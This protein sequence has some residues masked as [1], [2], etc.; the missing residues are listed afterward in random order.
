[1]GCFVTDGDKLQPLATKFKKKVAIGYKKVFC[2]RAMNADELKRCIET[3]P[4]N[5]SQIAEDL[6]I[7]RSAMSRWVKGLRQIDDRSAKLLRLY[8]Y[9]ELPFDA[10]HENPDLPEILRISLREWAIIKDYATKAG[11]EPGQWIGEQVRTI[12]A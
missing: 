9:G 5:Q 4:K 2:G 3:H 12:I 1:M 11:M 7:T 6:G 10:S 8:F